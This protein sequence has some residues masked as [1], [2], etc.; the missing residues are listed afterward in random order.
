MLTNQ[1]VQYI[2]SNEIATP[3]KYYNTTFYYKFTIDCEIDLTTFH[4]IV[5]VTRQLLVYKKHVINFFA[6]LWPFEIYCMK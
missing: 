4:A 3:I 5:L 1:E 6:S 2:R